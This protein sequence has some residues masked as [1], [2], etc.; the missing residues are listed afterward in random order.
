MWYGLLYDYHDTNEKTKD[1]WIIDTDAMRNVKEVLSH[2]LEEM[3]ELYS[4]PAFSNITW[5]QYSG[6][7]PDYEDY[8]YGNKAKEEMI[9]TLYSFLDIYE[10]VENNEFIME[11]I[12]LLNEAGNMS[13]DRD[14]AIKE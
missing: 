4:M 9:S 6:Y 8:V 2:V 11:R 10:N 1:L 7:L 5:K 12:D 3:Q 14:S 13:F